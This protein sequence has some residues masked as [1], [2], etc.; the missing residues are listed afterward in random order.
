MSF[1]FKPAKRE[2][3]PL[4]IGLA[5][6]TGSGKTYSALELAKGLS[7]GKPFVVIDTEN[8]RASHYA[9]EFSFETADLRAPFTPERYADAIQAA[10]KA[11]YG[12]VVVDSMSHEYA[13]DGGILDMH[14]SELQRMAGDDWK[15][16]EA[17]TFS[18][19]VKPKQQHKR[20]VSRLLQVRA[21]VILCFRAE[22]KIEIGKDAKGKTEIR[23]KRTLTG[24]SL[25]GWIPITEKTLPYEMTASFL[26]SPSSPGVPRPI[27]LPEQLKA[28]F[29]TGK[30]ISVQAGAALAAWAAGASQDPASAAPDG[31][32]AAGAGT[33]SAGEPV[34]ST[35]SA[36][37]VSQADQDEPASPAVPLASEQQRHLIFARARECG[38][39]EAGLRAIFD[40]V[41]GQTSSAG[42]PA[43]MVDTILTEIGEPKP[44]AFPIPESAQA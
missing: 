44:S 33:S 26:L 21:H 28:F 20:M 30:P 32:L 8:G 29:P 43:A 22:E 17:M 19:W 38:V 35:A 9:N 41:T 18:A 24:G 34:A 3:V 42:I 40:V 13:G 5:G 6:Y 12:V 1:Q 16:R 11:G 2:N 4:L 39:E 10:E 37:D 14:E 27:K 15:K 7:G 36:G 31:G 23:P 25:D